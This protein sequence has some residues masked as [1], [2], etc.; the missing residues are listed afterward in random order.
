MYELDQDRD[1]ALLMPLYISIAPR[2]PRAERPDSDEAI[3]FIEPVTVDELADVL[4]DLGIPSQVIDGAHVGVPGWVIARGLGWTDGHIIRSAKDENSST[5]PFL[6][7]SSDNLAAYLAE[8]LNASCKIGP[9]MHQAAPTM[10]DRGADLDG[11]ERAGAVIGEYRSTDG[12]LLAHQS[13]TPLWV[14]YGAVDTIVSGVYSDADLSGV[15]QF[16]SPGPTIGMER[17]GPWRRLMIVEG[18]ELVV[19]HE[20]G[21]EW[22]SV[23]PREPYEA[24]DGWMTGFGAMALDLDPAELVLDFFLPPEAY[25]ADFAHSFGL[26]REH[27]RQLEDVLSDRNMFDPFTAIL[28]ILELPEE[29][30][31]IAEGW[32]D[33][34]DLPGATR[35]D[36]Q[37]IGRAMWQSLTTVPQ[38]RGLGPWLQRLWITRPATYYVLNGV[39]AAL[40]VGGT[41]AA[42]RTNRTG[43]AKVLGVAAAITLA[44][45]LVPAR[46]RGLRK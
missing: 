33:G 16:H 41:Y 12:P 40:L 18:G 34:H 43:L 46:L 5:G 19:I 13:G 28:R 36:P 35:Y 20:W 32:R 15:V 23:D 21:P 6:T 17:N 27:L 22:L 26:T 9:E 1:T 44:D 38:E 7:M 42:A 4:L 11:L 39:E 8:E 14:T 25:A 37:P 24:Q 2:D 45:F 3:E 31:E 29:A 10:E 30:A